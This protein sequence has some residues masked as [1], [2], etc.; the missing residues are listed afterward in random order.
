[1]PTIRAYQFLR[2]EF[3][4]SLDVDPAIAG[5]HL[6]RCSA[7]DGEVYSLPA[8]GYAWDVYMLVGVRPREVMR[9][10]PDGH[11]Y[12]ALSRALDGQLR[13]LEARRARRRHRP[14]HDRRI[15]MLARVLGISDLEQRIVRLAWLASQDVRLSQLFQTHAVERAPI[16]LSDW[17]QF[18]GAEQADVERALRMEECSRVREILRPAPQE[19][20][21]TIPTMHVDVARWIRYQSTRLAIID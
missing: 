11:W 15:R 7:L 21:P 19:A 20:T 10:Q 13:R 8:P 14:P 6:L 1:M 2:S 5:L 16:A 18:L 9:K 17:S 12:L 4:S 3:D